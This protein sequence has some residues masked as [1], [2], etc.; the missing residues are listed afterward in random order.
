MQTAREARLETM[1]ALTDMDLAAHVRDGDGEAFAALMARYNQRL[2]RVA[3]SILGEDSAAEDVLQEAYLRAYLGLSTFRGE[4][5][6][7]TWLTRIV[8]NEAL[9][10]RRRRRPSEDVEVLDR[11][12]TTVEARVIAFPGAG[13]A[14]PESAAARSEIRRLL[15]SAVDG[16]PQAFRIVFLLR[17]VEGMSVEETA[18]Q[19]S[20]RPET[21]K[22][23]L[24]RARRLMRQALDEKLADTLRDTFPFRGARCARIA[25]AVL[26]RLGLDASATPHR[27]RRRSLRMPT[28][29]RRSRPS[30]WGGCGRCS[31]PCPAIRA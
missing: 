29:V 21:V 25:A 14:S 28:A 22:T 27:R 6:L 24:H 7:G 9:T 15:E 1:S 30:S 20:L 4:A 13:E 12:G 8:I 11:P 5:A 19:L 23:R 10:T 3:R 26:E 2:Y 16:L 17:E 31:R 18:A